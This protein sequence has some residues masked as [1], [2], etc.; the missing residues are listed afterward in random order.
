[1]KDSTTIMEVKKGSIGILYRTKAPKLPAVRPIEKAK[2]S[3]NERQNIN[4][5]Y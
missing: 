1:M 2:N 4:K 5:G 3:E